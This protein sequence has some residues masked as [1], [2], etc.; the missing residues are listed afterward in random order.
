MAD[1]GVGETAALIAATEGAETVGAGMTAAEAAAAA[2]SAA[3]AQSAAEAGAGLSSLAAPAAYETA[4]GLG[5]LAAGQEALAPMAA[6]VIPYEGASTVGSS[7]GEFAAAPGTMTDAATQA[8]TQVTPT[9]ATPTTVT[10]EAAVPQ[11]VTPTPAATPIDYANIPPLTEPPGASPGFTEQLA[12]DWDKLPAA[13]KLMYGAMAAYTI[14][15]LM[16]QRRST[17]PGS[18]PMDTSK[19]FSSFNR[20]T[21][22][23]SHPY[24]EGGL[25]SLKQPGFAAGGV[26][27]QNHMQQIDNYMETAQTKDGYLEVLAKA[28][29]GDY[30]AMIA[31]NKLNATPNQ[32]YARGG[33]ISSLGYYSDG[34]RLLRGPGTGL[35][36]G[37]P[38]Q[39]GEKQR[40]KLADGEFV[41]PADV[42]SALGG[43]STNSGA[44]K[45]YSMM[46]RI[47]KNAHG[48]K[49]QIKPVNDK[50][51][52]P[53]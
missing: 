51:V 33:G 13:K 27:Q 48:S 39:I 43:G 32:N 29:A 6:Q 41:V 2:E 21:F 50:K 22:S 17:V 9:A 30:N 1:M 8:A 5:S 18:K 35:S 38:A 44:N 49:Q 12:K 47:R 23:P 36:D 45:L 52:M 53:A 46:D 4:T 40:A 15:T 14:P 31:M 3:A 42:V 26:P 25:A 11:A 28:R 24:A 37:I 19:Y 7:I 10:P 20:N 16:S 34:G